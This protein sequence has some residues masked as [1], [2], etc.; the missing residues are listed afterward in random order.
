MKEIDILW[1][2]IVGI[3]GREQAKKIEEHYEELLEVLPE[4]KEILEVK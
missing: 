3:V 2:A 1:S 4:I